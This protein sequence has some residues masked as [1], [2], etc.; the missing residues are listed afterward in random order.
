[1][2]EG[3]GAEGAE[4]ERDKARGV[5]DRR[6]GREVKPTGMTRDEESREVEPTPSLPVRHVVRDERRESEPDGMDKVG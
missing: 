2:S 3:S 5:R 6:G 1:M 4:T